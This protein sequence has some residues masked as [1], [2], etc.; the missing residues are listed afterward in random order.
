MAQSIEGGVVI[1][2]T[3]STKNN[4]SYPLVMAE[5]VNLEDGQSVEDA[6]KSLQAGEGNEAISEDEINGLFEQ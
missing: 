5:S 3:L 6:I 4:G 2:N 1:V